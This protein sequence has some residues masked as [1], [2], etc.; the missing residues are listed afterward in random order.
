M[1]MTFPIS[2]INHS[3]ACLSYVQIKYQIEGR[4]SPHVG[5][6]IFAFPIKTKKHL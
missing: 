4:L 5:F 2:I 3:V 6:L 1:K